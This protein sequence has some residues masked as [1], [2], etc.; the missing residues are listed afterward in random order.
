MRLCVITNRRVIEVRQSIVCWCMNSAKSVKYIL[1]SSVKEVG[2]S[3]SA[4][5]LGCFCQAYHF[6]YDAFTQ[7]TSIL[8]KGYH[9]EESQK[10]VDAFYKAINFANN[11]E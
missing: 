4:T 1:P 6:Y 10:L 9:E 7:R 8:L 5:F 11:A 3:K 2:Y